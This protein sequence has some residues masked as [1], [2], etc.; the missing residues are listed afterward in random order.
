MNHF[1]YTIGIAGHV[2]HGKTALTKALTG[3]DTNRMPREKETNRSIV[4]G[5]APLYLPSGTPAALVDIPGH[6][7][8][9]KNAI[10]G[11]A[12]IDMAVLVVAADE[13]V[14][15]QTREHLDILSFFNI[16]KVLVILSKTDLVEPEL[17]EL[18][19]LEI[20]DMV[21]YTGFAR[22]PVMPFSA[23]DNAGINAIRTQID[24]DLQ[25]LCV[26]DD[27][28]PFRY[29]IDQTR[30]IKGVGTVVSGTVQSGAITRNDPV[31]ILPAG[32]MARARFLETH[33]REIETGLTGQRVGINLPKISLSQIQRGMALAAPDT[34]TA[35]RFINAELRMA[36]LRMT[37]D[38]R[39]SLGNR[40]RV[41]LFIG[42]A[43][44]S[45]MA[46]MIEGKQL[47][48]GQAGLVQF[49]LIDPL[50]CL[51][52]DRF[53]VSP[54]NENR[55]IGGGR[56]LELPAEKYR[57]AKAGRIIPCLAAMRENDLPQYLD[58]V[59]EQYPFQPVEA[60]ELAARTIFSHPSITAEI[61]QRLSGGD[62]VWVAGA[63]AL[64]KDHYDCLVEA[65]MAAC[66]NLTAGTGMK[67]RFQLKEIA[68]NVRIHVDAA[69]LETILQ[70]LCQK[71]R[72]TASNGQYEIPGE[73]LHLSPEQQK[74]VSVLRHFADQND[75]ASFSAGFFCK[76][77]RGIYKKPIVEKLLGYLAERGELIALPGGRYL[78]ANAMATI[79]ERL[80]THIYTYGRFVITD[81]HKIFG[82]G[83]THAIPILEY[84]DE[85]G[86][87]R[88]QDNTRTL[89]TMDK[90]RVS[91]AMDME[92][93]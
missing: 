78:S 59:L 91:A 51:P 56:V 35:C 75:L 28:A 79:K 45:A 14:M 62:L 74:A 57:P 85:M 92:T 82:Y 70:R 2:D 48:P 52:G 47:T 31:E 67:S 24:R 32:I 76:V 90:T 42:T 9:I 54:L 16:R 86:F 65:V 15:P 29:W 13:G 27:K 37:A 43:S 73:K 60:S 7:D 80:Q 64:K 36:E 18:A 72:L 55:L 87:T 8:Y 10:R 49:R 88:R 3:V 71:G 81:C 34:M 19:E 22:H 33:G 44:V 11:L 17:A 12:G 53:V 61:D 6:A 68:D 50:A 83:R 4:A 20:E 93:P 84:L 23:I 58:A 63:G 1:A 69:I 5:V 25:Q 40:T 26:K 41:R 21:K 46:V 66:K 38:G 89:A 77:N 39:K 30:S